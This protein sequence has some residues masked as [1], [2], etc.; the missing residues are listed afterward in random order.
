MTEENAD[1][2]VTKAHP[3]GKL[4]RNNKTEEDETGRDTESA[5]PRRMEGG[6]WAVLVFP[7]SLGT[8]ASLN[9]DQASPLTQPG[10]I[11]VFRA[12]GDL[13]QGGISAGSV[14]RLPSP[15]S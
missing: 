2:C 11:F 10:A 6:Y 5:A 1:F 14:Q 15:P 3:E 12:R 8:T 4:I 13:G 9:Y 7:L